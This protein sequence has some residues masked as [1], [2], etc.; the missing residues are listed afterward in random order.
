VRQPPTVENLHYVRQ[1]GRWKLRL[2]ADCSIDFPGYNFG[3]F[4]LYDAKGKLWAEVR[5]SRWTIKEGYAWD[6]CT[7]VPDTEATIPAGLW[8]DLVGQF[9]HT[10]CVAAVMTRKVWNQLFA[11]I[12]ASRGEPIRARIYLAGLTLLNPPYQLI[13]RLFGAKPSGTCAFHYSNP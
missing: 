1:P 6:G 11:E 8:H 3:N 7:G 12:I 9:W 5:G 2:A 13:G 4:N 10:A